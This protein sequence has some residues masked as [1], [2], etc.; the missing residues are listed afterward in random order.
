VGCIYERRGEARIW[1]K[2]REREM[3]VG[4]SGLGGSRKLGLKM[5][6]ILSKLYKYVSSPYI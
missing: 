4:Y 5:L 1:A 3:G 6:S 2:E